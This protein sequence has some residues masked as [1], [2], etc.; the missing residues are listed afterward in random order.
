MVFSGAE[1]HAVFIALLTAH[2]R[3]CVVWLLP[4]S[5]CCDFIH[6]CIRNSGC[7]DLSMPV[8]QSLQPFSLSS[9]FSLLRLPEFLCVSILP[10]M[11]LVFVCQIYLF[12][13]LKCICVCL[14]KFM[15][16]MCVQMP[17]EVRAQLDLFELQLEAAVSH[18]T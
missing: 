14:L 7:P 17:M 9:R 10:Y 16:S 3:Q 4:C 11:L 6:V 15:C 18:L 2:W 5:L 1:S 12:I 13:T 8:I